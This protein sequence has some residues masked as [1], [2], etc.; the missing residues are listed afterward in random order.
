MSR[1]GQR[2][3]DEIQEGSYTKRRGR[4]VNSGKSY[5]APSS[6]SSHQQ[7]LAPELPPVPLRHYGDQNDLDIDPDVVMN[8]DPCLPT[9]EEVLRSYGKVL[10]LDICLRG[11][12]YYLTD[13]E[14]LY[15][16]MATQAIF[17]PQA[18]PRQ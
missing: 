10:N 6:G 11:S 14:R 1:K 16:T 15:E 9:E 8:L 3:P 12:Y 2:I 5:Q 13:P 17:L 4:I 18:D 7:P